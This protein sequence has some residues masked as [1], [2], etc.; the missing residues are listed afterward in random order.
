MA[1]VSRKDVSRVIVEFMPRIIRGIHIGFLSDR[2]VT[3]TQFFV[4][5][6]IHASRRCSMRV[7]AE[8]MHISMPTISGIV[9]R[10]VKS[11]YV[12]RQED[13]SDRRLVVV[14]LSSR[15]KLLIQQFQN[16][17]GIRWEDI[18]KFLTAAELDS[19]YYLI[20]KLNKG[21]QGIQGKSD[22]AEKPKS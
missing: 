10:L 8:S 19:F 12:L 9:D 16:A 6:A 3:Q 7:L 4:V 18:L 2:A 13:P 14:E 5:T 15:G 1:S 11:G 21:I 20:K 22:A 17:A